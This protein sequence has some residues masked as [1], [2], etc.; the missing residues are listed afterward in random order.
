MSNEDFK[1]FLKEADEYVKNIENETN[2]G[3]WIIY[4]LE[5]NLYG[6]YDCYDEMIEEY[7]LLNNSDLVAGYAIEDLR[8]V[9]NATYKAAEI[10]R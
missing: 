2:F 6:E 4:D 9:G 10:Y 3:G 5:R 7:D 1:A 8:Q